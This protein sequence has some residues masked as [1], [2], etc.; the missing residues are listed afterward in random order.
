MSNDHLPHVTAEE[1]RYF[2]KKEFDRR[3][4]VRQKLEREVKQARDLRRIGEVVGETSTEILEQIRKLGFDG[5]TAA[6]FRM[7]PLIIVAWADGKV[8]PKE[9]LVMFKWLV[10]QGIAEGSDA[11]TMMATLLEK[12]PSDHVMEEGLRLLSLVAS[13]EE[14]RA[15]SIVD[16]CF[17]LAESHGGFFG[18]GKKVSDEE[19]ALIQHIAEVLGPEAV[20]EAQLLLKSKGAL[21]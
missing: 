8:S 19:R 5:E 18:L 12:R 15:K 6:V 1:E 13:H 20:A 9:R 10:N 17:A 4:F 21:G 7:L 14:G 2:S 16:F 11:W 3:E